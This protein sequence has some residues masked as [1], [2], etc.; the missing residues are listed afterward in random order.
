LKKCLAIFLL[1]LS[2]RTFATHIVGGELIY[3]FLGKNNG[4]DDV[5]RLTLKIYRD[6][7][8]GTAQFEGISNSP[9]EI[10][11]WDAS[12]QMVGIY[13]IGI[14]VVRKVPPSI[15]NNCIK[16][17][18]DICVEEGTYTYII[19]L[20]AGPGGY[21]IAYQRCCRNASINNL[22]NPVTQG[23]TYYTKIP[24]TNEAVSNNSPRF[25]LFPP[26]FLC[27]NK[28]FVFDHSATD[29]DGDRLEYSFFTPFLG[30]TQSAC[31]FSAPPY[32]LVNYAATYSGNYPVSAG[33]S[34][35]ID[36]VTGKLTGKPNLIGQFVV[37]V[38]VKEYRG[39]KLLSTHYRD[40]QF[41]IR[42]CLS[43][44]I[45]NF[46]VQSQ[47]C[48]GSA[49]SFTNLSMSPSGPPGVRWDFGVPGEKGDTS[50]TFDPTYIFPKPGA[51]TVSLIADPYKECADTSAREFL[52]Y[53]PLHVSFPPQKEQCL[54]KN[55]FDFKATGEYVEET[56]FR[57]EFSASASPSVSTEKNPVNIKFLKTGLYQVRLTAQHFACRDTFADTVRVV[58]APAPAVH[59]DTT[60]VVG[61]TV[62]MNAFVGAGY[63]YAWRPPAGLECSPCQSAVA[64]AVALK[65]ITYSVS[66]EDDRHCTAVDNTF[67]IYVDLKTSIDVPSAFT[68][69]GDGINDFIY[70]D[71]WGLK[72]LIYFR[73]FNRWG[74]LVFESNELLKGWDGRYNGLPQNMETYLYQVSVE[75]YLEDQ[76]ILQKEGSFKL[77]R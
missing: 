68:P 61:E 17:P 67:T 73:V 72:K 71:G 11:V 22:V 20:P 52:I 69:N 57:W 25:N 45:S 21:Y 36:P 77:L 12:A 15:N 60:V 37:G 30:C 46:M 23:A 18:N 38:C 56:A 51:Y 3:D 63:T 75:T 70:P 53:P 54:A 50:N 55:S 2:A 4:G 62:P 33:P 65:D 64:N 27:V 29:P 58:G 47:I 43:T 19:S 10:T 41:N 40:F 66:V 32:S 39:E 34:L 59:W 42:N 49:I 6:C 35:A 7:G 5:Y 74:Q 24:G 26:I 16:T 28:S 44:T 13:D 1:L 9:A 76:P 8:P 48:A 14:P 31:P